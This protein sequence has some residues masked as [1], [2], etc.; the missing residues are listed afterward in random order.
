MLIALLDASVLYPAPLRDFLMHLAVQEAFRARWTNQIHDEWIRNVIKNRPDLSYA[1]LE[2]T[3]LLMNKNAKNS[4]VSH[5]ESIMETLHLPD[6]DD[7]HVLAA[8]IHARADVIVT[9]NL[10]HFPKKT[11]SEF[12]I[13]PLHPD[14]FVLELLTD[15]SRNVLTAI[16]QQQIRLSN[17]RVTMPEL[18]E[19]LLQQGLKRSTEELAVFLNL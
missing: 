19:T 15:H 16:R 9:A 4:L 17:P 8:A 13:R 6:A 3:K 5:F 14:D 11:L 2:R 10:K 18:L 7:R 1:K 12:G